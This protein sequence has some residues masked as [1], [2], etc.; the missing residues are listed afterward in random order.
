MS[1]RDV[2]AAR[3][4]VLVL[5]AAVALMGCG[6]SDPDPAASGDG[7]G[8]PGSGRPGP[9][10]GRPDMVAAVSASKT[11]GAVDMRFALSGRPTVG[12][13]LDIEVVMTPTVE[14]DAL[15]VSFQAAE[16]LQLV[17][18]AQTEHFERP[19]TGTTLPHTVTVIP[20][21]DGIYY[22]TAVVTSDSPTESVSRNYSIPII[23]GA[24]LPE[25]P[26]AAATAPAPRPE[27]TRP[28]P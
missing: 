22:V 13:P 14:L 28:R 20:K 26:A 16:G 21:N 23:A 19:K 10:S 12:Q 24:G 8:K 2:G 27:S 11:P 5:T 6:S 4:A 7:S 17:K 3:V 15:F 18:G 1:R 25:L 9:P